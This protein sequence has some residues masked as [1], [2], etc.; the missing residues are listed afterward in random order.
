MIGFVV[1]MEKEIGSFI[2]RSTVIEKVII[3]GKNIIKGNFNGKE[4]V[5]V[6]SGIGKVN[7]SMS[8]QLLLDNFDIDL[9]VNFG[10]AGGKENS[11]LRAGDIVLLDKVCQYDFDLSEIDD[12]SVGYM[13]DYDTI[14][15]KTAF[16]RYKGSSFKIATG[17]TGDRF[18]KKKEYLNII[19][20]LNAQV[21]DMECGA[22]AQVCTANNVDFYS[23]KLI[24]DVD[25]TDETIFVQFINNVKEVCEKI[26]NAVAELLDNI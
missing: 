8:A 10:V 22:I 15:Y 5:L 18:T 24:S 16:E 7:A 19:K 13:Q 3:A 17:A 6:V 26:P 11:G 21:V 1:A 12:V 9:I 23:L 4:F 2:E 14:Y 25:G 20:I